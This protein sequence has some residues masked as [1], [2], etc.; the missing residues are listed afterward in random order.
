VLLG[1]CWAAGGDWD[2]DTA[3]GGVAVTGGALRQSQINATTCHTGCRQS[4]GD[5]RA[6]AQWSRNQRHA[7]RL[8]GGDVK[9]RGPAATGA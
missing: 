2:G 1:G 5:G 8:G 6:S 4:H 9:R 7:G 3:P